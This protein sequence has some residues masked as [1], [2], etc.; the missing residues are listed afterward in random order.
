VAAKFKV[1]TLSRFN[2]T[3]E[4][5]KEILAQA[6][7]ELTA[8]KAAADEELMPLYFYGALWSELVTPPACHAH[9]RSYRGGDFLSPV[10]QTSS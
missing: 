4:L 1:A 3:F 10:A 9:S 8:F 6:G 5:E 2:Q 7:A